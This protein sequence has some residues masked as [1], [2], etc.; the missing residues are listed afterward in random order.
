MILISLISFFPRQQKICII[1]EPF[2]FLKSGKVGVFAE[3]DFEG[4][5]FSS[6]EKIIKF[7]SR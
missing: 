2:G 6:D 7:H 1:T 5:K 3:R 4:S